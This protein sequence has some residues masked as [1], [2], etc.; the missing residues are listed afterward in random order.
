MKLLMHAQTST[1]KPFTLRNGQIIS[2]HTL[3]GMRLLIHDGIKV[4]PCQAARLVTEIIQTSI[5]LGHK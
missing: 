1:V 5:D 4:N 2:S 3:L